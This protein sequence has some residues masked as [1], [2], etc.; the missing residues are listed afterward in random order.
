LGRNAIKKSE[1]GAW[2]ILVQNSKSERH[3]IGDLRARRHGIAGM[4]TAAIGLNVTHELVFENIVPFKTLS[5][6]RDHGEFG[7]YSDFFTSPWC[8]EER[9]EAFV[10]LERRIGRLPQSERQRLRL[11]L[12]WFDLGTRTHGV[13]GFVNLWIALEALVL[14]GDHKIT[15]HVKRA[16]A[17][18]YRIGEEA[19]LQRFG[20]GRM[21]RLRGELFHGQMRVQPSVSLLSYL[22]ALFVDVLREVLGVCC[23]RRAE[24]AMTGP[25]FDRSGL[26]D[27]ATTA[28]MKKKQPGP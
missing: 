22:R 11:A 8:S 17:K 20:I 18:A 13:E 25:D 23:E 4:L 15:P 7:L 26:I 1:E 27:S 19:A 9:L 5:V 12:H 21:E 3:E 2:V 14:R 16:L 10:D 24:G 6:Q 28:L